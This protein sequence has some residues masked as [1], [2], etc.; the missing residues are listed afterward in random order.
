[1][2]HDMPSDDLVKLASEKVYEG[3]EYQILKDCIYYYNVL[4]YGR[5]KFNMNFFERKLNTIATS[6]N[7]NTMVKLLSLSEN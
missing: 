5:A 3:E 1:M 7:Y 2:L 6:R 4:G